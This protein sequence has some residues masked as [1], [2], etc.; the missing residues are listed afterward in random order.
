MTT[1]G[2]SQFFTYRRGEAREGLLRDWRDGLRD[3]LDPDTG[4]PFTEDV[5]RRATAHGSRFYREADGIDLLLMGLQKKDEF[6]ATQLWILRAGSAFL[7]SYHAELWG[8]SYLPAFGGSGTA[9][10]LG[11]PGTTWQGSTTVPDA[12][13][14]VAL[15]PAGQ[16]FQVLITGTADGAGEAELTLIGIDGG[17]ETNLAVDTVLTWESPPPGSEATLTVID[18]AFT[19]GL[20]AETDAAFAR[21]LYG[22]VRH[23]PASGNWAH[24]RAYAREASVSIEDAFVYTAAFNAGSTLVAITQKRGALL[25]PSARIPGIG[26][27]SAATL[28][29]VPPGSP[30]VPGRGHTV[31]VPPQPEA[32]NVVLRLAQPYGSEAGWTDA[33]PFPPIIAGVSPVTITGLSTQTDFEI[34]AEDP[35]L[36]PGAASSSTDVHLM[37][38]ND[39]TSRF[40]ALD[41]STVTDLGGGV[42]RV[43]LAEAP[44]KTLASGDYISPD[45]GRREAL[46]DAVTA[47]FD[48][49][50]PGEV[51]NLATDERGA[52][53]FRQ[54]VPEEESPAR[55]GQSIVNV[56]GEGLGSTLS[57]AQLALVSVSTPSLP[58][59]PVDG[60]KL[61]VAG[62]V[63]VYDLT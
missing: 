60:P 41:V 27:L 42:Y 1:P 51:V 62:R 37:V 28:A 18:N 61:I 22:R 10:A 58:S 59:D 30:L 45:M 12:F 6:L 31:V 24:L 63:A 32:S 20:D 21:R 11:V 50:G 40:E 5:I 19:G 26:V 36:L 48:S 9:K 16:R 47:Y 39:A 3:K 14:K 29:L 25:G 56:I 17:D 7:R 53:A 57:D 44:A 15:D 49:L 13:A 33:A 38:W 35:G 52:R 46:A 34:T 4:E 43:Q 54:P 23:K 55:A 8:E 2:D